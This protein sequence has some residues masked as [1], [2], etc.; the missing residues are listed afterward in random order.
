MKNF[1]FLTLITA[2]VIFTFVQC[3]EDDTTT[4]STLP[5]SAETFL[6]ATYPN[7]TYTIESRQG[8]TGTTEIN[9]ILDNGA[10]VNFTSTGE[11]VYVG[12][13]IAKVPDAVFT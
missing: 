13:Q 11:V 2:L 3:D 12:G 8:P 5:A 10:T 4:S 7:A 1:R 9:V 6:A